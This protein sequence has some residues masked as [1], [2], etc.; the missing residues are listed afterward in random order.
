MGSGEWGVG[1]RCTPRSTAD[2]PGAG[3]DGGGGGAVGCVRYA[4]APR[5]VCRVWVCGGSSVATAVWRTSDV[6]DPSS[7]ANVCCNWLRLPP[8]MIDP[9]ATTVPR[10]NLPSALALPHVTPRPTSGCDVCRPMA[11]A[12]ALVTRISDRWP[13]A[14]GRWLLAAGCGCWLL[15]VASAQL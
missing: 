13:L 5:V 11:A 15:A 14:A 4:L 6:V 1:S 2:V 7:H 9:T 8:E 12:S 3:F 10:T